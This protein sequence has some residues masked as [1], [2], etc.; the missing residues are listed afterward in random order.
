MFHLNVMNRPVL[1]AD[2]FKLTF[3]DIMRQ[4][5]NPDTR[6]CEVDVHGERHSRDDLTTLVTASD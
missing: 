3:G 5:S 6:S 2:L 1:R 4:P